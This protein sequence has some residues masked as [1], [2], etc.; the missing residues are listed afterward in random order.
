MTDI[1]VSCELAAEGW[2]CSVRVADRGRTSSFD[3]TAH[4]PDAL[5]PPGGTGGQEADVER[6]V[7]ETFVFLLERE[8]V[9]SILPT[10][11][12]AVVSRYFPEYPTEIRRRLGGGG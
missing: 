8:P 6:L 10:F 1:E 11:D 2:R 3:V 5:L 7:S 4:D 9:S 12:L